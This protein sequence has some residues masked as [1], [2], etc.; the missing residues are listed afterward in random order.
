MQPRLVKSHDA[1]GVEA[2]HPRHRLFRA[3][4]ELREDNDTPRIAW[5]R[6]TPKVLPY[7]E[8]DRNFASDRS[9][10]GGGL[11][12]EVVA[13]ER[14]GREKQKKSGVPGGP[15]HQDFHFVPNT[16]TV[17]TRAAPNT[18]SFRAEPCTSP[19]PVG[20][21]AGHSPERPWPHHLRTTF[22]NY[23]SPS[24]VKDLMRLRRSPLHRDNS[25]SS[26]PGDRLVMTDLPIRCR[27]E[28]DSSADS[29]F[30]PQIV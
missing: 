21:L 13:G 7:S 14:K 8:T 17:Y 3:W 11:D 5:Q 1:R 15:L 23:C 27:P 24:R 18:T 22:G 9:L 28:F 12:P 25:L 29:V 4:A 30:S 6:V 16:A 19:P 2:L 10:V 20:A 26:R